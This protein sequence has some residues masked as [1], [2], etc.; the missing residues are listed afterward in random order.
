MKKILL[1]NFLLLSILVGQTSNQSGFAFLKNGF[2][3][4][5]IS[6]SEFGAVNVNDVSALYYNPS[7]LAL[8]KKNQF[9]FSHNSL[10]NDLSSEN[11]GLSFNLFEIPFAVGINT[12]KISGIELRTKPGDAISK[13]NANYFYGSISSA[14]S[15]NEIYFGATIKYLYENI[16]TDESSGYAFDFGM[17]YKNIYD[18]FSVG[19]V[20]KNIGSISEL[21]NTKS[22]LPVDLQLGISYEYTFKN[23]DLIPIIGVQ[24]FINENKT[25]FHFANEIV[26]DKTFALRLGYVSNYDTK[27][28][29]TGLGVVYKSFNLDYAYIPIKFGLGDNHIITITYNF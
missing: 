4:R 11:L 9:S 15:I 29:T 22:K 16:Y 13:F 28:I 10:F 3:A 8:N 14:F 17:N 24:K 12:T 19:A 18:N 25:Y 7:Y 6:L 5:N 20:V 26:Y 23:F 1:I 27:N 21:R 2:S